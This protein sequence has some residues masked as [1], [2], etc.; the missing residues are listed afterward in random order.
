MHTLK[1]KTTCESPTGIIYYQLPA[2]MLWNQGGLHIMKEGWNQNIDSNQKAE[3]PSLAL[4][5]LLF[6]VENNQFDF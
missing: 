1:V 3:C 6:F 5:C 2:S 4:F